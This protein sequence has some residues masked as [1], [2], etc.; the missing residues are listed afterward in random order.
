MRQLVAV[1]MA[2]VVLSDRDPRQAVESI[3]RR[4]AY[5]LIPFSMLLIK[6]YPHYGVEFHRWSGDRMWVGV[7]Q[8]KNGLARMCIIG[9]LYLVWALV[10][11]W[12][13]RE[14]WL[15]R[16]HVL[17]ECMVLVLGAYLLFLPDGK[18][19]ATSVAAFVSAVSV[20]C[21]LGWLRGRG[22]RLHIQLVSVIVLALCTLGLALAFGHGPG[23]SGLTA[24]MG[25]D[26]TLTGRADTWA[27]LV[28]VVM[29]HPLFGCGFESY[30]SPVTRERHQMSN[31]HN[32]YLEVINELGA[33]GFLIFAM[34]LR[35]VAQRAQ[36]A[37]AFDY[38][39]GTLCLGYI[40]M[41]LIH[42]CAESST[43]S[44]SCHLAGTLLLLGISCTA[45]IQWRHEALAGKDEPPIRVAANAILMD[46]HTM[47]SQCGQVISCFRSGHVA[48]C[49]KRQ[50]PT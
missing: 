20:L 22:V 28:P 27:E 7:A 5:V 36:Q 29:E 37:M 39:W 48:E 1:V 2:F 45:I 38:E 32:A 25:R 3:L 42:G 41:A 34:F 33:V 46:P 8:Q 43:N 17:T 26:E 15:S 21:G 16:C 47:S 13:G 11:R 18:A 24:A 23:V 49:Q 30:W 50:R 14:P 44:F 19:S 12:R 4:S 40:G 9:V 35:S 6:Y 10:R 31:A